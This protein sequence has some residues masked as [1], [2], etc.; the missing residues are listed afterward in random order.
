M[1]TCI[2]DNSVDNFHRHNVMT[3]LSLLYPLFGML[4]TNRALHIGGAI[5]CIEDIGCVNF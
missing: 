1:L 5:V 4:P 3:R 2:D